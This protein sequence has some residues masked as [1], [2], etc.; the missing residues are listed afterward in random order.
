MDLETN[1]T[2]AYRREHHG[3]AARTGS[4]TAVVKIAQTFRSGTN[5]IDAIDFV[6]MF[7]N[8]EQQVSLDDLNDIYVLVNFRPAV[9]KQELEDGLRSCRL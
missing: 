2:K 9:T 7:L 3:V 5:D 1:A 8:D 4:D 6:D